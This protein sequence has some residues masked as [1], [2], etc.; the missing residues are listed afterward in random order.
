[1][2]YLLWGMKGDK[3]P[4]LVTGGIPAPGRLSGN[5]GQ[6]GTQVLY[7]GRGLGT[8][9]TSG[10]RIT[11]G[12]WFSECHGWGLEASAFFL[13]PRNDRFSA[14]G[15]GN[16]VIGRPFT[17][18][19]PT[20][21]NA[22][23]TVIN[24][25]DQARE[26]VSEPGFSAGRVDVKRESTLW[27]GDANVVRGL[28]CSDCYY[29]NLL[30]GYRQLGLNESLTINESLV[31]L[32]EPVG[33]TFAVQDRFTTSNRFYGGQ[34]GLAGEYRLGNWSFGFKG[35]VA[36]G[37]TQESANI[38][39]VTTRQFPG[40]PPQTAPGGL[41]ALQ[42]TN[43]GHY[44]RDE[45]GIVP[46][47]TLT[48]GYQVT[49]WCRATIGYNFL[50]WNSVIRPGGLIDTNVN[51]SFLPLRGVTPTGP[52]RPAPMFNTTDFWAQGLTLG[53]EFVW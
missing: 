31:S 40:N 5:L 41:L 1:V 9:P 48:I 6:P 17:S 10:G 52:A 25:G 49:P 11:L 50:Y 2:E 38:N 42:G 18:A 20:F 23:G 7:G 53:V 30:L 35:K 28:C 37:C 24:P 4:P 19:G 14:E 12:Y 46:E 44:F 47:G 16:T 13:G 34:I 43:I 45:F 39:G 51:A 15:F 21:V 32:I 22:V 27:G 29:L 8:D 36:L 26:A 33:T 3:T